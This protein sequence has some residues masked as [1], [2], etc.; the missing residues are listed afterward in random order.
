VIAHVVNDATA[1][2]GG[3]GFATALRRAWPDVQDAFSEWAVDRVR[4]HL[5][6]VHFVAHGSDITVASMI[7]QRGFGPSSTRRLR[8]SALQTCLEQ[9]A[10]FAANHSAS[11]HMPR[12][13]TGNGG[14]SWPVI[15][16]LV[17]TSVCARGVSVTVYDLPGGR[18]ANP[19]PTLF[20]A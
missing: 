11:V 8:Y 2:W 7:A 15:E 18:L 14:G 13:G 3:R 17:R 19:K 12:I 1:N 5:G 6:G 9:L 16:E 4:L 20:E 10:E